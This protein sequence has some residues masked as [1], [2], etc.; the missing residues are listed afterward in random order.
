MKKYLKIALGLI[1]TL[2]LN[3]QEVAKVNNNLL[4]INILTP[5][6]TFEKRIDNNKTLC[7]DANIGLVYTFSSNLG[8]RILKTPFTRLQ[9]R[10]YYN[11]E[12]RVTKGKNTLNNSGNYIG[13]TTSYYFK[14]IND[15]YFINNYDGFS[16]GAAW[17]LQRTYKN[18]LNIN[19][20]TGI[21][22]NF[23]NQKNK[24]VIPIVNFTF[25][26]IILNKK[27]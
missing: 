22:Y 9:F 8:N 23:S 27:Q 11:F 21:G 13:L 4:K 5:G 6:L 15:D 25:G 19:L 12:K 2:N 7:L 14:N 17:G 1:L 20:N 26:W 16:L 24:S 10:N 3:A 18:G